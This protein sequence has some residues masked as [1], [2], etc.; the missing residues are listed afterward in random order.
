MK[1]RAKRPPTDIIPH[2][3]I[4]PPPSSLSSPIPPFPL[5]LYLYQTCTSIA[6]L[7][8]SSLTVLE[9]AIMGYTD[10]DQLAINTIRVLAVRPLFVRLWRFAGNGELRSFPLGPARIE[11][12]LRHAS[13]ELNY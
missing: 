4:R 5:I 1:L 8:S 7:C 9:S 11:H 3:Q 10:L 12:T 2:Q 6:L 13:N